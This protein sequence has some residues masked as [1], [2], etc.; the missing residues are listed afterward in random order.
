MRAMR[1]EMIQICAYIGPLYALGTALAAATTQ[2]VN[3]QH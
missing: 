2:V 3:P 1:S